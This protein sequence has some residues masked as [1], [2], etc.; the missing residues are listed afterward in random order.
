MT[1]KAMPLAPHSV[2]HIADLDWN[3]L[4]ASSLRKD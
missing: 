4:Q 3:F 1:E 2:G